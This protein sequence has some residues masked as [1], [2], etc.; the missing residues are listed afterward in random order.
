MFE[1]LAKEMERMDGQLVS[2]PINS[3][4][5]APY[6]SMVALSGGSGAD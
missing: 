4:E 2:V 1:D 5:H 6:V 3:D